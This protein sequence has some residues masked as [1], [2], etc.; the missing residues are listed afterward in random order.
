MQ[1]TKLN[2]FQ[3]IILLFASLY[4]INS[5]FLLS[6]DSCLYSNNNGS[7]VAQLFRSPYAKKEAIKVKAVTRR[8]TEIE[9]YSS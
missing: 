6:S 8:V 7:S 4:T 1:K 5:K 2:Y 3:T 9:R